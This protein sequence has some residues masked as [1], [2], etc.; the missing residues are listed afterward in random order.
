MKLYFVEIETENLSANGVIGIFTKDKLRDLK[1]RFKKLEKNDKKKD[2][3]FYGKI[4]LV[5]SEYELNK[6]H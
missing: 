2:L 4:K 3:P 5:I 6:S 1:K